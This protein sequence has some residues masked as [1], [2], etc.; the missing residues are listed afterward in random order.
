MDEIGPED[1]LDADPEVDIEE[2]GMGT[3]LGVYNTAVGQRQ[4]KNRIVILQAIFWHR[5]YARRRKPP[6]V[7]IDSPYDHLA[8]RQYHISSCFDHSDDELI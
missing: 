8:K 1:G 3:Q 6:S 2:A 4:E 5:P 7:P